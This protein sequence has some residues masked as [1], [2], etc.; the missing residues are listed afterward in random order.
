MRERGEE[1]QGMRGD[2]LETRAGE[3]G[4]SVDR[5]AISLFH[6]NSD[7]SRQMEH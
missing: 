6:A 2:A 4:K 7:Q 1:G 3:A 5:G